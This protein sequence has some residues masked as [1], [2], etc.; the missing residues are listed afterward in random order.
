MYQAGEARDR[1][2][3]VLDKLI[4]ARLVRLTEGDTPDDAQLEVAHEALVRNWFRLVNWLEDERVNMRQRLR[5]TM[6]VEQT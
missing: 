2:D 5:L 4:E 1:V 6:A 3:R